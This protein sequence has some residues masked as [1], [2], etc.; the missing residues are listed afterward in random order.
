MAS[1]VMGRRTHTLDRMERKWGKGSLCHG[2]GSGI[3]IG[4]HLV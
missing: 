1:S 4:W 2:D 3:G